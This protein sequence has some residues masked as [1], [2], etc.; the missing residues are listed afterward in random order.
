MRSVWHIALAFLGLGV[1]GNLAAADMPNPRLETAIFAGGCFWS[2]EAKFEHLPGVVDVVSG[3][4]GGRAPKSD[5][6]F[7][8]GNS[9]NVEA[10]KV[11]F[12]PARTSYRQLADHYWRTIDP[13]DAGGQFCD[14]GP[15][16]ATAVFV[17]PAQRAAAEA[18]RRA[19]KA[20]LPAVQFVTPIRP[21]TGFW[22]AP[23]HHQN[24]ARQ[25]RQ[26]YARYDRGCGRTARLQTLW[27]TAQEPR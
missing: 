2:M 17:T 3:A 18:S 6:D 15:T 16:Y 27:A 1:S 23:A 25:N 8:R 20:L 12:D 21:V 26:V 14:R 5:D 7:A 22:P 19:A 10:I 13:G 24:F 4:T 9:G 11:S